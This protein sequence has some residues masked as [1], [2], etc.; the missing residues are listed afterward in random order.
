[1]TT[2]N[3]RFRIR[4]V[5]SGDNPPADH[6][7]RE[8]AVAEAGSSYWYGFGPGTGDLA[9][10]SHLMFRS[11]GTRLWHTVMGA[12]DGSTVF[13]GDGSGLTGVPAASVAWTNVTGKP[14]T[15]AGY[16]ITDAVGTGDARLTDA[17]EWTAS[18][19]SQA[20]AEAG[21]A[22]TRRAWTAQRVWQAIAAWWAASAAK[23]KLDG[24]APGATANSPDAT[25]LARAN[26]TGTQAAS[27]ITGLATV[28]TSG[29]YSDL[30]GLPSLFDGTWSSLTGKPA[31]FP[32]S[33]HTHPA[34]EISDSTSAGRAV[35]TAAN[36]AAQR[37][38]LGLGTLA[39]QS[40]TFSG[41]SSGT[42]TGDQTITLT[43]DVT[44]TGTGSFAATLS[45][46][47]V[48]AGTYRSVTVDA[49]GRVTAGTNPT[50][51]AGYGI[52]D[53]VGSGDSRL[54]DAR[55]WTASTVSQAEAEAGTA[56]TRR[57]WTAQRVFQAIAAWWA[58]S[59]AKSKLDGIAT[60]ATVGAD[61]AVNLTNIPA[62]F[63]PSAHNQAWSTITS[64][65][66]TL[67]GYGITDATPS[68]HVGAGG[69]AHAAATT[70]VAGFMSA[71]DKTKLD[72][73][74]AGATVGATWGTNLSSIPAAIDAIDGLT[75][76]ADRIAYYTGAS[77]AAL[78][79][80]TTAGR[81]LLDDADAAA[82]R[83]TLG[84]GTAATAPAQT[85]VTDDSAAALM[86]VGAFGLGRRGAAITDL[87]LSPLP[88]GLRADV[89]ASN[90]AAN[91]PSA[92]G[93]GVVLTCSISA[94]R[95]AQLAFGEGAGVYTR[96]TTDGGTTW[97]AW[98]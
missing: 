25:L 51:L 1:M 61:W 2:I 31:T 33:A 88:H 56:T 80:L 64:T 45:A 32:P 36:A 54:T 79:T 72:G 92:L 89:W 65:P 23:S 78:A 43:G 71:A 86:L 19:V 62:S 75:P 28:A 35:L 68:S 17:R 18:T 50:T 52:T 5:T 22:T 87:N 10:A 91:R 20:E 11:D 39:T 12:E 74:A 38:A 14:T 46:T 59:S 7:W 63:T 41:T 82:Q 30:S 40:G 69:A 55:E 57:A 97:S 95:C 13:V 77:T 24:I 96:F 27:T 81:N 21:S 34:S 47:G 60:G 90:T 58:A 67:A 98:A 42:N 3:A 48:S 37:T 66:T 70:S 76:A 6:L 49:K 16:G 4:G 53:A 94:T 83:T 15:L 8:I 29:A 73:I 84:L 93:R 26:H 44:G 9:A 85:G